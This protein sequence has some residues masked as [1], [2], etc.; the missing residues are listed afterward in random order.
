[1]SS[2]NSTKFS[3]FGVK[4]LKIFNT[5][6]WKKKKTI[7]GVNVFLFL[8][9]NFAHLAT[10]KIHVRLIQKDFYEKKGTQVERL[11]GKKFL[12]S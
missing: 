7:G 12:K 4:F 8:G 5:K 2:V 6:K 3:F 10:K 9:R 1:L 11:G